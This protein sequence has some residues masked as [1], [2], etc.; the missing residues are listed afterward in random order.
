MKE[1]SNPNFLQKW[2]Y[3]NPVMNGWFWTAGWDQMIQYCGLVAL[4][5]L[6]VMVRQPEIASH[7]RAG[8]TIM[9]Q[10]HR[11]S[12]IWHINVIQYSCVISPPPPLLNDLLKTSLSEMC[13]GKLQYRREGKVRSYSRRRNLE[14]ATGA[15]ERTRSLVTRLCSIC[16][17]TL[18]SRSIPATWHFVTLFLSF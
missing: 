18:V 17:G 7:W 14:N 15:E 13:A 4:E 12:L 10:Q 6:S 1:F 11:D 9:L 8:D 2:H 5:H 16:A 3:K